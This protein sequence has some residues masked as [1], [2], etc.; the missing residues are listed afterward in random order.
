M[1][2]GYEGVFFFWCHLSLICRILFKVGAIEERNVLLGLWISFY[3][4]CILH[5]PF[6]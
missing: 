1:V 2:G 5:I 6:L 3:L 4:D